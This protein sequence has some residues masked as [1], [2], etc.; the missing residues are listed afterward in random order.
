MKFDG[1]TV[2]LK[3]EQTYDL[4]GKE[5]MPIQ[6]FQ[7]TF[8]GKNATITGLSIGA[9]DGGSTIVAG[10]FSYGMSGTI[11]AIKLTDVL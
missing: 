4:S 1:K 8:D 9:N 6:S 7:G 11:K 5:W 2:S 10:L 3:A